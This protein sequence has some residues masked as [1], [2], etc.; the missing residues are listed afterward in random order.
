MFATVELVKT[1]RFLGFGFQTLKTIIAQDP[2]ISNK[3][4]VKDRIGEYN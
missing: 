3:S 2:Y 4:A 1:L